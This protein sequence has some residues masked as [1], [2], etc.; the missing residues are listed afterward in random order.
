MP[1]R[2]RSRLSNNYRF[3]L[4]AVLL[5]AALL[6]LYGLN[7]LSP[8]GLEHDEVA[9]WLINRDILS[10]NLAL[11]FTDA[12]GHEAGFHYVQVA[13]MTLLGDNAFTLRL[14][15]AFA[16]LL[17]ISVTFA[18]TRRLY[19]VK[20]ALLSATLLAV[21]FWPV[22]Y[23]RLALRAIALPLLAG[24]S[25]YFWWKAW[26]SRRSKPGRSS[27][28]LILDSILSSSLTWFV[29]AGLFAGLTFYT[30]LASRVIPFFFLIYLT[31]LA[32]IHRPA[33]KSHWRGVLLFALTYLVVVAPL[34]IYL[35]GH[36][37]AESR[38]GEV[39]APLIALAGGE[40][41]PVLENSLKVIAMFGL[42][43]DPL[44][45][46]NV[47]DLPVFDP[48]VA[49]FFYIG[50]AISLW[51]WR[52]PRH[53]FIVLWLFT[54]TIPSIVT[55]DAPSS[56]RII[57]ALPVI[58]IFPII[59]LEVIH[60]FGSLSTVST[61]LSP[62]LGK[63][64]AFLLIAFFFVLNGVRTAR[65]I[66][67]TWPNESEVQFV[68]QGALT[69]AAAY[70]DASADSGP[71]AV[72]GYS[73]DTMDAPTMELTLRRE[74]LSLRYFDPTEAL[75]I[76]SQEDGN[77]KPMTSR[78][79]HPTALPVHPS[80]ADL[81]VEWS[82]NP[83]AI[84]SFTYYEINQPPLIRPRYPAEVTFGGE[85]TLLGYD[86]EES[87]PGSENKAG[88]GPLAILTYWQ[89]DEAPA[90]ARRV[91]LHLVDEGG[92]I[93]AQDDRLGAPAD[94]WSKGDIII[95]RLSLF[96]YEENSGVELRL[97]VYNP[98]SRVRL[99]TNQ[100]SEFEVLGRETFKP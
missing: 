5:A 63:K 18:F 91:F 57:N 14:P 49:L 79:I 45:R 72:G 73:A 71:V 84:N 23:S 56:I 36:P 9:H 21:L 48:L 38:I 42:R 78:I 95:Q 62:E 59:G 87:P 47:A 19:G 43:G 65:A 51:R 97:G 60:F 52:E 13:F 8:P 16:G 35:L 17:L 27:G 70:L 85:L 37:G 26:Q 7:N 74:D 41:R 3:I 4:V 28:F 92:N 39:D 66:F 31:Y 90:G 100:A 55:I 75:I 69:E 98:D 1:A 10:G 2:S 24:L 54:A 53:L 33:L 22:F 99:L 88:G 81:L 50:L 46:Q 64:I 20:T 32:L 12:Y 94:H 86:L 80:L 58:A 40:L 82:G 93:V 67:Q 29:V 68:W 30:Y 25:A 96:D 34:A 61:K 15:S 77:G 11:Y 89:V 44:W 83:I 76:P 6:R